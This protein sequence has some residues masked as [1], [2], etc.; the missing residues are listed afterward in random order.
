MLALGLGAERSLAAV[1]GAWT[2]LTSRLGL[3]LVGV[4]VAGALYGFWTVDAM[5]RD[6]AAARERTAAAQQLA[7][8]QLDAANAMAEAAKAWG[9]LASAQ[10]AIDATDE[11]VR[12]QGALS[13]QLQADLAALRD[14]PAPKVPECPAVTEQTA[15]DPRDRKVIEILNRPRR[16]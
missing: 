8:A 15:E 6:A 2:F 16:Q 7:K 4:A 10:A 9:D 1:R 13:S 14:T 12:R 11:L 3:A 5:R